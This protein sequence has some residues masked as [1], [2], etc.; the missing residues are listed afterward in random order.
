MISIS[1]MEIIEKI[2]MILENR[3][4]IIVMKMREKG[5]MKIL[6][7]YKRTLE[8]LLTINFNSLV[9]YQLKTVMN[10]L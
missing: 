6:S 1:T 10:K 2:L 3:K 7:R 5:R 9:N 4:M 8:I